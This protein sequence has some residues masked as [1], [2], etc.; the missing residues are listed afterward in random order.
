MS[1]SS[2]RP[3]KSHALLLRVNATLLLPTSEAVM[4]NS[5]LFILIFSLGLIWAKGYLYLG[6]V[7]VSFAV[8]DNGRI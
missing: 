3:H 5:G 7:L 6:L 1:F 2:P 4:F 8:N